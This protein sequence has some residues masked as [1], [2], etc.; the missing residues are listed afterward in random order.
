MLS[1]VNTRYFLTQLLVFQKTL[2]SLNLE[3]MLIHSPIHDLYPQT[4][5]AV[6]RM[7]V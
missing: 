4:A 3:L 1:H 7:S 2:S 5:Q 6:Y